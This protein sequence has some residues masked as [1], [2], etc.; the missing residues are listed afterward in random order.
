MESVLCILIEKGTFPVELMREA[1]TVLAQALLSQNQLDSGERLIRTVL[2]KNLIDNS[3]ASPLQRPLHEDLESY[4]LIVTLARRYLRGSMYEV[5]EQ[6][7]QK[8]LALYQNA[9]EK[10]SV[11]TDDASQTM[12]S[13]ICHGITISTEGLALVLSH[14]GRDEKAE[15][16]YRKLLA[17][18]ES[19]YGSR[20]FDTLVSLNHLARA[21]GKQ[22]K[23][24]EAEAVW[25]RVCRDS[26][27]ILGPGHK[28]TMRNQQSYAQFL[29]TRS[30]RMGEVSAVGTQ[31]V[32]YED[33]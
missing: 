24:D 31:G 23:W 4:C 12:M 30:E 11:V 1:A 28:D 14:Q 19:T 10:Y 25:Q 6:H 15:V 16:L 17:D 7:Y 27:V 21:L 32:L 13:S 5:A 26:E 33:L 22:Q 18:R 2:P 9:F 8:A 20:G 29:K 3:A